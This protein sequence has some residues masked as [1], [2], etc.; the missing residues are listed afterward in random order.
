MYGKFE[1]LVTE[2][3]TDHEIASGTAS[4]RN[5]TVDSLSIFNSKVSSPGADVQHPIALPYPAYA[6]GKSSPS[7]VKR[8]AQQ[9]IKQIVSGGNGGEHPADI[10]SFFVKKFIGCKHN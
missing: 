3:C 8:K 9:G 4:P 2:I 7:S 6:Y 1:H 5:D 10:V